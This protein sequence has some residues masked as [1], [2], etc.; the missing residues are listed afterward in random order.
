MIPLVRSSSPRNASS[1]TADRRLDRVVADL[2]EIYNHSAFQIRL[3]PKRHV[4]E[5]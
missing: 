1:A 5:T 3:L 4:Y 2:I